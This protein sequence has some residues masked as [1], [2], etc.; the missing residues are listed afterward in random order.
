MKY[1]T[2]RNKTTQKMR[3]ARRNYENS[4]ALGAKKDPK[5]LFKYIRRQQKV[6]GKVGSL[7]KEDG[8][9]TETDQESADVLHS[10][11]L[12]VFV[13]EGEGPIPVCTAHDTDEDLRHI[14]IT[15]NE[16]YEE[17]RKLKKDKSPGPDAL[18]PVFLQSCALQL[19]KPFCILFN[20]TIENGS[21]PMAWKQARITPIFKKGAR[22]D[23]GNF[24][25][26]SLTSQACK[27]ME[28]IL[29]KL[30]WRLLEGEG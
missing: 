7:M 23:P 22:K 2:Q 27:V 26:V 13:Q 15:V 29:K 12:S 30:C 3:E 5:K 8:T 28:R 21:V 11:F 1:K 18:S 6:K 20:K 4:L 10:F 14:N 17:L 9:M 24:R 25:P 19:A 16:V